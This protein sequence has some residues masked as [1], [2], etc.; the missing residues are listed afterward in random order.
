[1]LKTL[2][3]C[4]AL[5][6]PAFCQ[7]DAATVL[8]IVRDPSGASVGSATVTLENKA[9]GLSQTAATSQAGEYQF[10]NVPI[11]QYTM[12]VAAPDMREG[13]AG[14]FTV[15]VGARQ[16]VDFDLQLASAAT[17][18]E[19][20]ATV[21]L[22]ETD[23]SDR[24][25]VVRTQEIVELPLNGRQ[26]SEL[27]YLSTG[28]V[29]SPS[30]GQD[31]NS[32]EGSFN[33]NGLRSTFNNF[34]LDGLDNN[35]YGTSNQGFSNQVTQPPPDAVQEFRVVTNNMSAEYGRSGGA[36]VNVALR[37]GTNEF[38]GSLWQFFRNDKLN[39]VGFFKPAGGEKPRLNRNQFGFAVGGPIWKNRTFF[40]ADYEGFRQVNSFVDFATLPNTALRNGQLGVPVVNVLTR[41]VYANGVIPQSA[42]SPFARAVLAALPPVTD[43]RTLANNY[44]TLHRVTAYRDKGDLKVDH[45]FSERVRGFVR[46]DQSRAD[47]FDPGTIPGLAGGD[48]NGN[49]RIPVIQVAGGITWTLA[50]NSILEGRMGFSRSRAGKTPVLAGGPSMQELFGIPGL[51]T[52]PQY[53]GGISYQLIPGFTSLGRQLTNPQYQYPTVWNPKANWTL[54]LGGHSIKAGAEYQ[55]VH[56]E[57]Q[58]IHPVYGA[59]AYAGSISSTGIPGV[60]PEQVPLYNYADFLFGTPVLYGLASPTIANIR[61]QM[62]FG[63]VQDD[64]RVLPNLTLNLGLRYE[65][66]TPVYER[67]NRLSNW[68]PATNEIDIATSG[69]I[70]DRALVGPDTNNFAPRVGL[71]WSVTP[72]TV[73][74]SGYGVSYVHFNRVGSS[75]LTLNAPFAIVAS[76]LNIPGQPGFRVMQQGIPPNFVDPERYD[77]TQAA[78][79]HMPKDSPT[80][81]VQ[82]WFFS[83]QREL[84]SNFLLDAAYVGNT[85]NNLVLMND[86]NQGFPNPPGQALPVQFR[87]PNRT[88]GSIVGIMPWG[89]SRYNGLQ[90]KLERRSEAGLYFLNSFT[91]SK[92]IDN[93]PQ[94]LDGGSASSGNDLPSVQNIY[95]L[96]AERGLSP[97]D[98][99]FVNT[100]S[101]VYE[102]PFG[103]GRRFLNGMSGAADAILGGW[104]VTAISAARSGAPAT[105]IY[106]PGT[107]NEVS[108][109]ITISGRNQYR[110]N[111]SGNPLAPEG[112]RGP[113]FY[114]DRS[115]VSIPSPQQ[116]FGNA[117]R[118][119]VRG[120]AFWQADLGIYKT[121][122]MTER[123]RLQFRAESF[124]A[125]NRTNFGTPDA[126]ISNASFGTIRSTFDP[127]QFQFALKLLF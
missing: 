95:D 112:Q 98:R 56:V 111:I 23:S 52:D 110:A 105:P 78:I 32:R 64:W 83:I 99:K 4:L 65:Y 96:N 124:N 126:N 97:Y 40:F 69:S 47:I 20:T 15:T 54:I 76:A 102:L 13:K 45:N 14:P 19:V 66:A 90:V 3:L 81:S 82:S 93:G 28:I 51:P 36:T 31:F 68:N 26:Y 79:Q 48:G 18:V 60:R 37:S 122:V 106:T 120:P 59:F 38:H 71:A 118:N 27:V 17:E 57:Q 30:A 63:Y 11:G 34:L 113:D 101:V 74:R 91:W 35:Y 5:A 115:R 44:R 21:R 109:L 8:G 42:I 125:L 77:K 123:L 104:Q 127:R 67:D 25:Q 117:G 62:Y 49:T 1:M 50:S 87:R 86:L 29:P 16:R 72:R 103:K 10:T 84:V 41:Q 33:A 22:V 92:T 75:Y 70:A 6:L 116:P 88:W 119:I 55:R 100:T 61:Q 43:E 46:Y 39:A 9:T 108:P 2:G 94:N 85:S 73:I 53:T 114:L 24:G 107:A 89:F 80:A 121:F 7:F 58:D 12:T